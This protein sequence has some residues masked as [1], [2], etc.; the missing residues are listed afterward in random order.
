MNLGKVWKTTAVRDV[1]VFEEGNH[2]VH[3]AFQRSSLFHPLRI[4][5]VTRILH[6][7]P[8]NVVGA[9]NGTTPQLSHPDTGCETKSMSAKDPCVVWTLSVRHTEQFPAVE[10]RS[11]LSVK[12]GHPCLQQPTKIIAGNYTQRHFIGS[13]YLTPIL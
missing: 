1:C 9:Y 11:S 6:V 13:K 12:K 3:V 8:S 10:E 5:D 4:G 7:A 2:L